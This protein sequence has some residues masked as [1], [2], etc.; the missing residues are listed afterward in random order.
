[1]SE[2]AAVTELLSI[3]LD[4][5]KSTGPRPLIVRMD[6]EA[7][8]N[9]HQI[10]SV[11]EA[12][13]T[14]LEAPS[15]DSALTARF[16]T[17]LALWDAE[18][19]SEWAQGTAPKTADRRNRV[20]E[21]LALPDALRERLTVLFPIATDGGGVVISTEFEAWYAESLKDRPS[22]YWDHYSEY[23]RAKGWEPDN[24]ASLGLA[25]DRVVERLADPQR[26][27]AYRAKGLV[28]GYVQSGKTANF[29]GVMAKAIDAGYRLIIVLTGTTDL[30]R[31]QTQ[32]R[33]DKELIGRENL[34]RR[35]VSVNDDHA[36]DSV[37]YWGEP[38]WDTFVSHGE[39]P[40]IQG[41]PDIYRLTTKDFDYKALLQGIEALDFQRFDMSR[42]LNAPEN[43]RHVPARVAIVKKNATV[44]KRL[45]KDLKRLTALPEDIPALVIDDES[46]QASPNTSNPAKW[47]Q[48]LKQRSAINDHLSDLLQL[49]PRGQYVGYTAT[50]FANVFVDPEDSHDIFPSSFVVSLDRPPGYMGA[51]DFHDLAGP[52]ENPTVV[53]SN[54]L[55]FVRDVEDDEG[56]DR[57]REALDA[58]VLAGAIKLFREEQGTDVDVRHHTMLLHESIKQADHREL[59]DEVRALW[60]Q[61]AWFT[62]KGSARLELLYERDHRRVTEA[63]GGDEPV[64]TSF[65]EI[66]KW[67]GTAAGRIAGSANDPVWIVNGDKEVA[68]HDIDFDARSIWKVF[69][70]GAKLSRGFTI[71]GLTVSYYVRVTAQADTLMQMGR[72]FGFRP[73]YR[74]LVRLYIGRAPEG[75]PA[76]ARDIYEAFEAAC[77]SEEMFRDE[78][79]KYGE[80]VDGKPQLTPAEVPPLVTQHLRWLRPAATNKMYNARLIERRTPG[81]RL[82][83]AGYPSAMPSI[84]A[85][86]LA[87]RPLI[88]SATQAVSLKMSGTRPFD[89]F[90][91]VVDHRALVDVLEALTWMP[92]DH[93]AADLTWLRGL[94]ADQIEEWVVVLP[95]LAGAENSTRDVFG[96][97][98]SVHG[99]SRR[100]GRALFSGI[101]DPKHRLAVDRVAGNADAGND[102]QARALQKDRRGAVLIYP[103]FELKDDQ[104]LP[105]D[106]DA[107]ELI[108]G[109]VIASPKSTGSPDQPFVRFGV[110]D[111]NQPPDAVIER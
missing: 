27:T 78:I 100:D 108:M 109:F 95:Q 43:L 81:A 16:R 3:S 104:K 82:E 50:P 42:P 7:Q 55:A 14:A 69:I 19:V 61:G 47:E 1:M 111:P 90:Y 52:L 39:L 63:R 8:L 56:R 49:L 99:R 10:A 2:E 66:K 96:L 73:G 32:R 102:E 106:I 101:A 80:L 46:D 75:A 57:L 110:W 17:Q 64:P 58:F 4:A 6:M 38:D 34:L 28:V 84:E 79:R 33:I 53:T 107:R 103:V 89:A 37:D 24:V 15:G 98:R 54:E 60:E 41:H 70:G 9:G 51:S 68:E 86:A 92:E 25:T 83:P 94:T 36:S 65:D 76:R 72:W 13:H 22:F 45:V 11:E 30:L 44:L 91:S 67:I 74:D 20:Y 77:R 59:A 5:M 105:A 62:P 12:L 35:G 97:P 23:L 85:N 18:G 31:A 93:F 48:G 26:E 71:E 29:T 88:E 40:S 87:V 21:Q